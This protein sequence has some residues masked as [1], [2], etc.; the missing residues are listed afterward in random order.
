MSKRRDL[1]KKVKQELHKSFN[2]DIIKQAVKKADLKSDVNC[3]DIIKLYAVS[4]NDTQTVEDCR[5]I[6]LTEE[7]WMEEMMF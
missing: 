7:Q 6:G 5:I 2:I 4:I 3:L 1:Y